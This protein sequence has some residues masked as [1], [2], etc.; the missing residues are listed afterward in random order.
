MNKKLNQKKIS[1][2]KLN[3]LYGG[4]WRNTQKGTT[5]NS[6]GCVVTV[7][8]LYL[9]IDNNGVMNDDEWKTNQTCTNIACP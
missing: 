2:E 5:T 7:S 8:D 9:D 6:S 4:I 3:R 1:T